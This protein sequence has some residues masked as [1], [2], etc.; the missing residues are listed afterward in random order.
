[1]TQFHRV[2]FLPTTLCLSRAFIWITL[3]YHVIVG[4]TLIEPRPSAQ[5]AIASSISPLPLGTPSWM[6]Q[7]CKTAKSRGWLTIEVAFGP[8]TQQP[9]VRISTLVTIRKSSSAV[10]RGTKV[11]LKKWTYKRLQL[12]I[13]FQ[14]LLSLK[15]WGVFVA[16]LLG[17]CLTMLIGLKITY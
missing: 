4:T 1:M 2:G 13:C 14:C 16:S 11:L 5:Q 9:R 6:I 15:C 7:Y 12:N 3:F 8:L 17:G 10:P